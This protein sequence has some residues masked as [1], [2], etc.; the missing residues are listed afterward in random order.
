[1]KVSIPIRVR[2]SFGLFVLA[3]LLSLFCYFLKSE[4][5]TN[6]SQLNP[7]VLSTGTDESTK[8]ARTENH[9]NTETI[10]VLAKPKQTAEVEGRVRGENAPIL[11]E[12]DLE[13]SISKQGVP[14]IRL[15]F[16]TPSGYTQS[17]DIGNLDQTTFSQTW[18][19]T[20]Q[21]CLKNT[22]VTDSDS[23][24]EI[25][26]DYLIS[27]ALA[28]KQLDNLLISSPNG[29][30]KITENEAAD[31]VK[32]LNALAIR[33]FEE[34]TSMAASIQDPKFVTPISN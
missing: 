9:R 13:T 2:T 24:F 8:T 32:T 27:N 22:K 5:N 33:R 15:D 3:G 12:K 17:L 11:F 29:S 4:S 10:A 1:M 28:I 34:L 16:V 21:L 20:L 18:Q 26:R 30:R 14:S 31:I 7:P 23:K 25:Q 19:T 6:L